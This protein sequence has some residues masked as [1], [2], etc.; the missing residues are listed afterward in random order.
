MTDISNQE[1]AIRQQQEIALREQLA[2]MTELY[3]F[4][5]RDDRSSEVVKRLRRSI[6]LTSEDIYLLDEEIARLQGGRE[7][8]A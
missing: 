8:S 2:E 7:I 1:L 5:I 3:E 6:I 4:L